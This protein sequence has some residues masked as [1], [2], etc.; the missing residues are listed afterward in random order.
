ME[1]IESDG[2]HFFTAC[3]LSTHTKEKLNAGSRE[4][5]GMQERMGQKEGGYESFSIF[6]A[7]ESG[8]LPAHTPVDNASGPI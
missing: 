1:L 8:D 6:K 2:G 7:V 4:R 3:L 5:I